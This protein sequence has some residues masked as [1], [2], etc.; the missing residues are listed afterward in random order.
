MSAKHLAIIVTFLFLLLILTADL[1][2]M[3]AL[4]RALYD[5][6]QGDRVGHVVLFTSLATVLSI[7]FPR[8]IRMGPVKVPVSII[9]LFVF[10]S[11]E[12][13]SQSLF[14]SRTADIYDLACTYLGIVVGTFAVH[15][16][17]LWRKA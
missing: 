16:Y 4:L 9:A 15:R 17:S 14:P 5:F 1:G 6:P 3:P 13:C 7:A 10:A 8:A 11:V 12:E 2:K